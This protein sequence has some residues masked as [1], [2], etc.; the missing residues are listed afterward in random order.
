MLACLLLLLLRLLRARPLGS[1]G[2]GMEGWVD[3]WDGGRVGGRSV[4]SEICR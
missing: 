2:S 4:E 3:G 1:A